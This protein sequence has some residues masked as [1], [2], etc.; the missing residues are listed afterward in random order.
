MQQ[1]QQ[2]QYQARITHL[3]DEIVDDDT[4]SST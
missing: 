3:I 4:V 2:Q 1:Q